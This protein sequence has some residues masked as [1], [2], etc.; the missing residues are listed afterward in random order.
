MIA[1]IRWIKKFQ[2]IL[3]KLLSRENNTVLALIY[4]TKSNLTTNI[5]Y[6]DVPV[7]KDHIHRAISPRGCTN[8]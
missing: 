8:Y 4:S 5:D 1:L 6:V 3:K 2:V 7:Y